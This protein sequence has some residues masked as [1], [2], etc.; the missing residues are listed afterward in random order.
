MNRQQEYDT[1]AKISRLV[2]KCFK[3]TD[4]ISSGV[5]RQGDLSGAALRKRV[6]ITEK[7]IPVVKE[8][9]ASMFPGLCIEEEFAYAMSLYQGSYDDL[10]RENLLIPAAA[11]WIIDKLRSIGRIEEAKNLFPKEILDW[12]IP[13]C[14][15]LIEDSAIDEGLLSRMVY[16]IQ[17][18]NGKKDEK[19]GFLVDLSEK[20]RNEG[21]TRECFDAIIALIPESDKQAAMQEFEA[22]EWDFLERYLRSCQFISE[23]EAKYSEQFEEYK[24]ICSS[25]EDT[26]RNSSFQKTSN[27]SA[28]K[29]L[30]DAYSSFNKLMNRLDDLDG[31]KN[32]LF[33]ECISLTLDWDHVLDSGS[34]QLGIRK[35]WEGRETIDPYKMCFALLLLLDCDSDSAWL[36]NLGIA[37]ISD[38]GES[39]PWHERDGLVN[40][41]EDFL[42]GNCI[43]PEGRLMDF[44]ESDLYRRQFKDQDL[45]LFSETSDSCSS[46]NLGQ[47]FFMLTGL[48]LP[49]DEGNK[50]AVMEVL[51]KCGLS[52]E[53]ARML[54]P[55][56]MIAW[57]VQNPENMD[58]QVW[59]FFKE[60]HNE[61]KNLDSGQELKAE[62]SENKKGTE[63]KAGIESSNALEMSRLKAELSRL[64]SELHHEK[65]SVKALHDKASKAEETGYRDYEELVRLREIVHKN[66][67]DHSEE[68]NCET[69]QP[70]ALPYT[71]KKNIVIIGG[72]DTWVNSLKPLLAGARFPNGYSNPDAD[73]IRNADTI[74]IQNNALSHSIFDFVIDICRTEH[75]RV[76]YFSLNGAYSCAYEVA[77]DDMEIQ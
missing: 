27:L 34:T 77:R 20:S 39:L 26:F 46:L 28:S 30:K 50:P 76:K 66:G 24:R 10:D 65:C 63:K 4:Q 49:R 1:P 5:L 37:V 7:Y 51:K 29:Q 56:L 16:A 67:L 35:F 69:E 75:K 45:P 59:E 41:T 57:N 60:K 38:A 70:I 36:Y 40:I 72:H 23:K 42:K 32:H 31:L 2:N 14:L 22:R 62:P 15:D 52:D 17:M 33:E 3:N 53:T 6:L 73:M 74:W 64:R 43:S 68:E 25:L 12:S 58:D 55:S 21:G 8:K 61:S 18:R 54:Y 11:I 48:V 9:Y 44:G 19:Q 71:L 47:I 13:D